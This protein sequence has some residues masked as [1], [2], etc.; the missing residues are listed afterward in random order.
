MF[1]FLPE[2]TLHICVQVVTYFATS[3]VDVEL[4]AALT[5]QYK[6]GSAA[7][8]INRKK[9]FDAVLEVEIPNGFCHCTE[10]ATPETSFARNHAHWENPSP[11]DAAVP[12]ILYKFHPDQADN[13]NDF[14]VPEA[15]VTPLLSN[16]TTPAP[17][18]GADEVS[19]VGAYEAPFVETSVRPL[20][21]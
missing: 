13:L 12:T 21:E 6:F 4:P 9:S 15:E 7:Y 5:S 8:L 11:G 1:T 17:V 14:A 16:T 10:L 2:N 3:D 19:S 18:N 20:P